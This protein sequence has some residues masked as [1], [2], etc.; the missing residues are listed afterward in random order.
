MIGSGNPI[1][2]IELEQKV[3][4]CRKILSELGSVVVAF[5]GGVDSTFLLAMAV[6]TLGP[7]KVLAAIGVSPSLAERERQAA[8]DLARQLGAELV[9]VQTSEL[10]DADYSANP[11]NRCFYCKTDLFRRLIALAKERGFA[12][13]ASGANADD[14]GD[15]RPGLEAGRR[16]GVRNPLMESG[17]TKQEIRQA[18]RELHLPTW[19]KPAMACLA[20]RIPYGQPITEDRLRRIEQAEYAL[21]DLGFR[22]CRVRDH[23]TLARVEVP[24]EDFEEVLRQHQAIIASLKGLGYVYVTLDLQ[25]FRSGAMNEVLGT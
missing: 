9:E 17:L 15:F 14:L 3:L 4:P 7:Q 22:Q 25:G 19:D 21:K 5:S 8:R 24:A 2:P 10:A 6:R 23:Q 20:S 1:D 13:V 11:P 12:V 18:S 16:L